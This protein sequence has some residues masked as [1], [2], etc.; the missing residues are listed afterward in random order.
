MKRD[1]RNVAEAIFGRFN[2]AARMPAAR[3]MGDL[4]LGPSLRIGNDLFADKIFNVIY[5]LE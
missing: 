3:L 5:S 4:S 2:R 1:S